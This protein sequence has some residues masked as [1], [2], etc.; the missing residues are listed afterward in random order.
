MIWQ[1]QQIHVQKLYYMF[2]QP[3]FKCLVQLKW[4]GHAAGCIS[5][6]GCKLEASSVRSTS[7]AAPLQELRSH[8]DTDFAQWMRDNKHVVK[9][10]LKSKR[11]HKGV[12]YV[13]FRC[14]MKNA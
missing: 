5:I 8:A 7:C 10:Q 12:R 14:A 1:E 11:L 6:S 4:V 9:N 3:I 2:F 13:T